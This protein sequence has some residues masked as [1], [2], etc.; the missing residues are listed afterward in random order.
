[1]CTLHEENGYG[2][3]QMRAILL[4]NFIVKKKIDP[5][6]ICKRSTFCILIQ[7]FGVPKVNEIADDLSVEADALQNSYTR[8][9]L[10]YLYRYFGLCIDK[11]QQHC[12][13]N[14]AD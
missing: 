7:V 10:P 14:S 3:L 4:F 12:G 11:R 1:M 13:I 9:G 5:V 2:D 8:N 6:N